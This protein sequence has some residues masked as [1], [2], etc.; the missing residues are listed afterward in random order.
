LT[1]HGE[2]IDRRTIEKLKNAGFEFLYAE[3][4]LTAEDDNETA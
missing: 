2:R 3:S 4:A 1:L